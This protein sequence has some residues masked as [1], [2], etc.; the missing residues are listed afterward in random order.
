MRRV[1]FG[2]PLSGNNPSAER[3]RKMRYLDAKFPPFT[4]CFIALCTLQKF[5]GFETILYLCSAFRDA[6]RIKAAA[7]HSSSEL[8]SAWIPD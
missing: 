2:F 8:G 1:G 3:K 7:Q 5:A 6:L 4:P